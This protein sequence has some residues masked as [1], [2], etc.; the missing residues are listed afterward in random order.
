MTEQE[1]QDL[2]KRN[3]ERAAAAIEAMGTKYVCHPIN[4]VKRDP[5]RARF[6]PKHVPIISA[7]VL[8]LRRTGGK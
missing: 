3:A 7:P 6:M 2:R 4:I 1:L 5:V 8:T